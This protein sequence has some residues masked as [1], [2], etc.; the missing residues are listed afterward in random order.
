M[1]KMGFIGLMFALMM[2]MPL[3]AGLDISMSVK[4]E[5][6]VVAKELMNP[7]KFDFIIKSNDGYDSV[8]FYSLVGVNM[9]P[10]G[11]LDIS[12]DER[13][14]E[15]MAY[16]QEEMRAKIEGY[17]TF[18]Y[19]IRSNEGGYERN[20]LGI[21][22]LPLNKILY[23]EAE[24]I[25]L[26]DTTANVIIVNRKNSYIGNAE[27]EL[28][29]LFFHEKKN[30]TIGAYD[31]LSFSVP[32]KKDIDYLAAGSYVVGLKVVS[33]NRTANAEGIFDYAK[34]SVV[35]AGEE[36]EG[37]FIESV[38]VSK[39]NEGNTIEKVVLNMNRSIITRLFTTFSVEPASVQRKGFKVM[40]FWEQEI[41]PKETFKVIAKT[42]YTLP[43]LIIVLIIVIGIMVR[44]YY[45]TVLVITKRISLVRTKGGEFALRVRLSVKA[46]KDVSEVILRDT[47]PS[48]VKL[49]DQHI[50]QPDEI[51]SAK[52]QLVWR[53]QRLNSGEERV[54][55]YIIYS[56][57]KIV[58]QFTLPAAHATFVHDGKKEGVYSNITS[59]VADNTLSED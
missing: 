38:E 35:S 30:V 47:L 50:R 4:P 46:R 37:I 15:I 21:E 7:A 27:I 2:I 31:N 54:F 14:I 59:S 3:V 18:E 48:M 19:Y 53:I 42:N 10:K 22:I 24:P 57:I 12:S 8:E 43:F 5:S 58:G 33:D 28:S 39:M 34:K 6:N 49:Y 29:S 23:V 32:L 44:A 41:G 16:P 52:R 40:Y 25:K 36:S 56:K 9:E 13:R 51:D 1:K 11:Y 55:S 45:S 26:G 17:F 20:K